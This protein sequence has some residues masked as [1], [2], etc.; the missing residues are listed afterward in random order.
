MW[1]D[2]GL[3]TDFFG[4]SRA[5]FTLLPDPA[6]LYW[7]PAHQRAFA[8]LEYGIMS[9]APITVVTGEIGAGKTTLIQRLLQESDD[10]SPSVSFPTPRAG[11][12][13]WCSGF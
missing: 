9:R 12:A 7:S 3:Y 4:L 13:S 11:A 8:V 6:F 2:P 1:S 5:P 10:E